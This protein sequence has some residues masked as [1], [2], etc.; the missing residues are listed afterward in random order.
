MKDFCIKALEN[1]W[2]LIGILIVSLVFILLS[3]YLTTYVLSQ[4]EGINNIVD[5]FPHWK[6]VMHMTIIVVDSFLL[7]KLVDFKKIKEEEKKVE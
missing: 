5:I 3:N 2:L 6:W 1:K 7:G 4:G